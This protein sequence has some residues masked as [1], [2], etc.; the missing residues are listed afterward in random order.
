MAPAPATRRRRASSSSSRRRFLI[1]GAVVLA[2][3]VVYVIYRRRS[4]GT[5][6]Q[7]ATSGTPGPAGMGVGAAAPS[8]GAAGG[9]AG[10]LPVS[11]VSQ[12]DP[13][14]QQVQ[15]T[16]A[17]AS[18]QQ[19]ATTAAATSTYYNPTL[20]DPYVQPNAPIP[21]TSSHPQDT[22]GGG[23]PILNTPP[24]SNAHQPGFQLN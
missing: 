8:G 23:A 21:G 14:Q 13:L 10:Q 19:S 17:S 2:A 6:G 3:V 7:D 22:G 18:S 5:A 11:L 4:S 24:G 15:Q 20:P 9:D 1:A 12:P 16:D